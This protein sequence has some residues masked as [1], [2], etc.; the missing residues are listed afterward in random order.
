MT[1]VRGR[2]LRGAIPNESNAAAKDAYICS[3]VLPPRLPANIVSRPRVLAHLG[4]SLSRRLTL[5]SAPAGFGKTTLLC[6]WR[7]QLLD[8][9]V[10]SV[11]W[12]TLDREDDD[13]K[14]VLAAVGEAVRRASGGCL[15]GT[16][17]LLR[18]SPSAS[19]LT[20]LSVLVSQIARFGSDVVLVL[21]DYELVEASA[22]HE[23]VH[24]MLVHA[25]EN[26]HVCIASRGRL[27]FQVSA[28]R[29]AREIVEVDESVLRFRDDETRA[30]L[31]NS[32]RRDDS[33]ARLASPESPDDHAEGGMRSNHRSR[34]PYRG[35]TRGNWDAHALCAATEGWAAGL[36][37]ATMAPNHG[38]VAQQRVAA[39]RYTWTYLQENVLEG[40]PPDML[41]FLLQT[42]ILG[43]LCANLCAAV[44][45]TQDCDA[46]LDDLVARNLFIVCLDETNTW[47]RY[48][49]LFC[50]VLAAQLARR[51]PVSVVELHRRAAHWLAGNGE[52]RQAVKHAIAA[53]DVALAEAWIERCAMSLVESGDLHTLV[54]WVRKLSPESLRPRVGLRFALAWT[55]PLLFRF[56]EG[57]AATADLE[58]DDAA[59]IIELTFPERLELRAIRAMSAALA[60]NE[61]VRAA[62][63]ASACLEDMPK[64]DTWVHRIMRNVL[65]WA[66]THNHEYAA[67][68]ATQLELPE[69]GEWGSKLFAPTC[70]N[71]LLGM[72]WTL[73]G[74]LSRAAALYGD[75]AAFAERAGRYS[76]ASTY[77][78][79]F[80]AELAYERDDLDGVGEILAGRWETID[81]ACSLDAVLRAY[82]SAARVEGARGDDGT[83][84]RML[85]R[86]RAIGARRDWH[87]LVCALDAEKIRLMLL[88]GRSAEARSCYGELE[89]RAASLPNERGTP[90]RSRDYR[91]VTLA[92]ILVEERAYHDAIGLLRGA[93]EHH[94]E[95]RANLAVVRIS[96]LLAKALVL[97]QRPC[98]AQPVLASALTFAGN[99][100]L[101][102]SF[103]DEGSQIAAPLM[104]AL[105]EAPLGS[106]ASLNRA[107]WLESFERS[108]PHGH[109][110]HNSGATGLPSTNAAQTIAA[111]STREQQILSYL[112]AGNQNKEIANRLRVSPETVK[113]HLKKIY[114]KLSVGSRTEATRLAVMCGLA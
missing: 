25:P 66:Y 40:L 55:L 12:L 108:W 35:D 1:M 101:V 24:L 41:E 27:P 48:H 57:E 46:M 96:V 43:P 23:A 62:E 39:W 28:W 89:R 2:S 32:S 93:I 63:L 82:V 112:A 33:T 22:V 85:E 60:D 64:G 71:G 109:E 11:A 13:A 37:I 51:D 74:R 83:A 20:I 19:T 100:P 54:H 92:R 76:A 16:Q 59:S 3:K 7:K 47:F 72:G 56:A 5:V 79:C 44:T 73:Q 104:Q 14:T 107:R 26:M 75:V 50:E 110:S 80:E 6:E 42:S 69:D 94:A 99:E 67:A 10:A 78:A 84:L 90:E 31:T 52:W 77:L 34:P 53:G 17:A 106:A 49:R 21:D 29:A 70:R 58:A 38:G 87:R 97:D 103:L 95:R 102:R 113:W 68:R 18:A 98:E 81:E 4:E 30:F 86:G 91:D 111:L 114:E 9:D 88:C 8:A 105:A 61:S 45:G 15:D 65:T 36:Q